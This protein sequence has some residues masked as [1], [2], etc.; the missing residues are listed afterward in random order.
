ML[1][2][3]VYF[4]VYMAEALIAYMYFNDNYKIK[5]KQVTSVFI[6]FSL[7][8][9]GFCMNIIFENNLVVNIIIFLIINI[10]Y[11]IISFDISIKSCVLHSS[12]LWAIMSLTELI[13]ETGAS[14]LLDIPIDAYMHSF[15]SLVVLG[16]VEKV[17]YLIVCKFIST[18]FSYKKNNTPNN[19][20]RDFALFLY[21]L[22]TTI[23]LLAYSYTSAVY[24]FSDKINLVFVAVS[25]I[26]LIFCCFIFVINQKI[27]LQEKE[28]IEL[29]AE[30][31]KNE[32]NKAFYE[33]L[34]KKNEEHRL[35]AHDMKH[36]FKALGDM[37]NMEQIRSYL[38]DVNAEV[39]EYKY[40]GKSKN[41]MLDM[42]LSR[43]YMQCEN[44][45]ISFVADVKSC[46]LSFIKDNDLSSMLGNLLDNAFEA[47]KD[48]DNPEI[49]LAAR[50]DRSFYVLTVV[51]S[52][53]HPPKAHGDRLFTTKIDTLIHGHGVKS[54]ERTAKKYDGICEWRY[55]PSDK[56]FH[57]N[58]IFNKN[59][60]LK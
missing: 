15:S 60:R 35:F 59:K 31:Q 14:L 32:L 48:A 8:I 47:A 17:L 54:V 21:P 43:Y 52:S 25:V 40:I 42:I 56:T 11:S 4:I 39:A 49:R 27:Q 57:F 24:Q 36:H 46:N 2:S 22:I 37:E 44:N 28:L 30:N 3:I 5:R 10:I 38:K 41:K 18:A 55:E 16:I 33:L 50:T 51:N 58:I 13:V 6:A 7:Y 34:E 26:A 53:S 1:E 9:L 29:Q 19:I 45:K 23:M 20:K 12:I